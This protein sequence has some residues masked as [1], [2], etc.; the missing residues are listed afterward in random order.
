MDVV[1]LC[2][3]GAA[4]GYAP[5]AWNGFRLCIISFYVFF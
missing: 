1:G 5:N 4:V 3:C 2:G